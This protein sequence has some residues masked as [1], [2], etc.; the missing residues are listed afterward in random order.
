MADSVS[1]QITQFLIDALTA[2]TTY[3][4]PTVEE[5]R[6]ESYINGRYPYIQVIGPVNYYGDEYNIISSTAMKYL[7]KFYSDITEGPTTEPLP[8]QL[9]NLN[10]DLIVVLKNDQTFGGKAQSVDIIEESYDLE[11]I[12]DKVEFFHYVYFSIDTVV[13]DRDLTLF[14]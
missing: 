10:R 4:T 9:K 8:R 1:A 13:D 3:G 11:I 6:V 7:I 14:E 2:F 12:D 5:E